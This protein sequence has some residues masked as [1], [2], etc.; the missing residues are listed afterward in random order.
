M[1]LFRFVCSFLPRD[2][3]SAS[4]VPSLQLGTAEMAG[5]LVSRVC[6]VSRVACLSAL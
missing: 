6:R 1:C 5:W 4:A 3:R 2:A